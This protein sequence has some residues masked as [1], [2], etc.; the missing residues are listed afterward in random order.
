RATAILGVELLDQ[1]P[2]LEPGQRSIQGP[3]TGLLAG[4]RRDVL[5]DRVAVLRPVAQRQQDVERWLGEA[6]ETVEAGGR[7]RHGSALLAADGARCDVVSPTRV[8][9]VTYYPQRSAGVKPLRVRTAGP[10]ARRGARS[11]ARP[12]RCRR[13]GPGPT[14]RDAARPTEARC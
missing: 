14:G 11:R 12:R 1:A 6:A 2:P 10:G 9:R 8:V 7:R 4:C 3:R 13:A 5:H